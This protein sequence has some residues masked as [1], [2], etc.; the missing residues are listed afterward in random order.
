VAPGHGHHG[1]GRHQP[2]ARRVLPQ[3]VA[4]R[5]EGTRRVRPEVTDRRDPALGPSP[6]VRLVAAGM[7]VG[8]DEAREN[9]SRRGDRSRAHL[10]ECRPPTPFRPR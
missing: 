7:D 6:E 10:S 4:D 8:V 1:T 5:E 2:R 3:R 9:P